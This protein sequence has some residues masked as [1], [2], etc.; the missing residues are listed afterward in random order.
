MMSHLKLS[1]AILW[2]VLWSSSYPAALYSSTPSAN[3]QPL[4]LL[5]ITPHGSDVPAGRQIV[6]QFNRPVVP[7]GRMERDPAE[8]PIAIVP[9]LKCQWRW[10]NTS[11]LACQLDEK[12]ALSPATRY[13]IVVESGLEAEDGTSLAAPFRHSFITERPKVRH[14]WFRTWK[15]PGMPLIRMTF[16]QP[17]SRNSVENHV[18]M[19]ATDEPIKRVAL[20]VKPD[21]KDKE[22]PF[23][24]PLPGE[25]LYLITGSEQK[26]D[27]GKT[28]REEKPKA[29]AVEARRVWLVSPKVE[30][31]LDTNVELKVEPG[32][33]SYLGPEKGVE[34]RIL[35][36]FHTFPDFAFEGI[37]CTD[38]TDHK[39]TI[40]PRTVISRQ[41]RCNPLARVALVFSAPVINETVRD[42]VAFTPDLA[43][44]RTDYDPWANR[45]G[46]SRL[47]SPHKQGRK[48]RVWL[49]EVLKAYQGYH[50][51]SDPA[52]FQDEFGRRL[53]IAIDMQF[54][55]DHRLPDF[56]LTH[57]RAVLEKAIDTEMPLVVTNLEE[58]TVTYDRLT[59]QEKITHQKQKIPVPEAEDVS[60]RIP[61]NIRDMLAGQSGVV[62]GTV[63]S[64]PHVSKDYWERWFFAQVTPFQV[65]VKVGHF[66]T[67]VWITEFS[68]AKPVADASVTIYQDTYAALPRQPKMLTRALTDTDGVAILAGTR[69]IDPQLTRLRT[70]RMA[71]P[72][73]FVRVQKG[74]NLALVPLDYQFR[75]DTYRASQYTVS[76]Y[77]RK[78]YGHIHTWGTT[79]QGVYKAGDTIQYKFYVRNQNNETFVP[80]PREGYRLKIVDPMGKTVREVKDLVL[81]EFGAYNGEFAVPKTGAVGWYR[82][83]L[84][85]TFSPWKWEPMRVLVS[86]FTPAAFRV[87]TDLN[88]QHFQSEDDIEVSTQAR[89]HAGG[90]Y[91]DASSRV[92]VTLHSRSFH[93]DDPTAAGFR[94]DTYVPGSRL[95]QILHQTDGVVDSNGDLVTRFTLSENTILFGNL[96]V[97]SAVR[98]DRGKYITSRATAQYAGRD[99]YVGLRRSGWILHED[100]PATV[101]VL[102]VDGQGKPIAGIPISV[103]IERR[104]TKAARVK[105]AGNAYLTQYTHQWVDAATCRLVSAGEPVMCRFTPAD[106]GSFRITATIHDTR[107]RAHSTQL[108]QWVAG[109]GRVVW[110]DR[111]DNSLEIIAEKKSYRV[112]E[113]ARYLV[114]NPYPGAQALVTVERY[115]V[116]KRWVQI[117]ETSTPTIEFDIEKDF[118]PGFFLSVVVMSPRVDKPPGDDQ[119]DLGKPA[120]RM[121]YVKVPVSDPYK[122]IVIAVSPAKDTYK[123]RD[124]VTVD[125]KAFVRHGKDREPIELAVAVL[126]EAVFD[127]IVQ[128]RNYFDPYKGFYTIDGL[129]LENFSLL[130]RLVG[131]QKFEKKGANPAAGGGGDIGLRSVFKFV[132][133]WNPSIVPDARGKAS[134]EFEAPDNLTGWR[135]LAMAVTP[136]DRMGLGEG[137]F[138]VNR[139]TEIRPVM[140]NQVTAGDSF[141][142]GFSIMNR[143]P[144]SRQLTITITA[145]GVIETAPGSSSREVS[146]KLMAEPYQ[147]ITVWI[148]LITTSSGDIRFTARGGD[149]SDQ[150]GVVHT[151]AVRKRYSLETAATYGSTVSEMVRQHIQFPENMRT[152]VGRVSVVLAPSVLGNLEGAFGYIRDYEYICWEQVL[153]KGVMASHYRNLKHYLSDDFKWTGSEDLPQA[154][155]DRAAV[156]QAPNG[157]MTYYI[158]RNQYVSPYLSAYTAMAFNWLRDSGYQIPSA[159]E[160]KLHEYLLTLLRRNVV[161]DF[162]SK[163]MASTVRAVALAALVKH[164]RI[165][166]SDLRRYQPH[167]QE[168]SLFGKAHFL[169]A[170]LGV[171]GSE[172]M[173]TEVWHLILAHANQSGGKFV[174]SEVIDDSYTRILSS[175][176]RTNGAVLSAL[177]EYGKTSAG[178]QLV[179]DVPIKLVRYITQTRKKRDHWENTQENMF[180]MNALID[181]SRVYEKDKPNLTLRALFD[182]AEIGQTRFADIRDDAVEFQRSIQPD[183]PGRRSTLKLEREGQGRAYYGLRLFYAPKHLKSD[184]INAG[185]EIHREYSVERDG[186]WV[187]LKSP[188]QLKRGE[189]VRVDLFVSLASARNFVVVDDPVPGGLE[190]VNRDLATA[191]TV[192]ADKGEFEH[193]GGSWWFRYG[194]WSSYGVSRWS[195]Y[196]QELRHDSARF[197]SEYL[198]A[199]NYHLS[200][201]AQAIA[202]GEF[203]VMPVHSEEM[204][205]PDVFG[206]GVPAELVVSREE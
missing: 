146:Q 102:A 108:Y 112:G 180:C 2:I 139:P 123:P 124:R 132:S 3:P 160:G 53:S 148:P 67:L 151:L 129:D 206:K 182:K 45:R 32:L 157:G 158:P 16:N 189:L 183:D 145:E 9:E 91:A 52:N 103:K 4:E 177:V 29:Q 57:P 97:E 96:I 13:E 122:E 109:K 26:P 201:T 41:L 1:L 193:A 24:L 185:I 141:Q 107:G 191:S 120:F 8:I 21:P 95:K 138:K 198:P 69:E 188:M 161:P 186:Q 90:P 75:I 92:T 121:G 72:R 54:A 200:Y 166:L 147:R 125:L 15:A 83:Q 137:S 37:E 133:Y 73:L 163:G 60:F 119:V 115:G 59:A 28:I 165:S 85:A 94:F 101:D 76:P 199:G 167:V 49:P 126:D 39:I 77:M 63:D 31:A 204:Y 34:N 143:T 62:Q 36:A 106:P 104:E 99:R 82:F 118:I 184:P 203:V 128:G 42:H 187:L 154:M 105:G 66:N 175:A 5:R 162:Y 116:L 192:D 86:D 155:L 71:D 46:Y 61:L 202:P 173:R 18:F 44:G 43:G 70:Y 6:F 81:S 153:T 159:V 181:Y 196:H 197:Y 190:A 144:D 35:V 22:T 65:H 131:R 130:T 179:G 14:A 47:R 30:L 23:I 74:D 93:S 7:V 117:L 172:S 33:V 150:D 113:T 176:L 68:T 55:T 134:I 140:P 38:N 80:A 152:D 194:D 168:M 98:D 56:S 64:A 78:R 40:A 149:A 84:A 25:K 11:A 178:R 58:V 10:L 142:A 27:Q 164:G 136:G 17:V 19:L 156:Y 100:Q 20:D 12:A 48:Y 79:A 195:F 174:F 111:P 89:L 135:V 51:L 205:D 50:I 87:T 88:G 169:L 170:A 171:S 114:K 110:D 127:L